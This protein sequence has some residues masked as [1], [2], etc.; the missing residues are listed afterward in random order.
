MHAPGIFGDLSVD[1]CNGRFPFEG[2]ENMVF[3]DDMV[4]CQHQDDKNNIF[5]NGL[6]LG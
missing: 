4:D 3:G 5:N 6:C 2:W 1:E